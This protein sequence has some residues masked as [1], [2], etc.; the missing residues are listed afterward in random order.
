[1]TDNIYYYKND[2][3]IP[4]EDVDE[5]F[6]L[7]ESNKIDIY[8]YVYLGPK[9]G[10]QH[11]RDVIYKYLESISDNENCNSKKYI[12]FMFAKL[13]DGSIIG[14]M[15]RDDVKNFILSNNITRDNLFYSHF[16]DDPD[17]DDIWKPLSEQLWDEL[18]PLFHEKA[19]Y[20]ANTNET[21]I[22][23]DAPDI[24]LT[25]D[26]ILPSD[27]QRVSRSHWV[28]LDTIKPEND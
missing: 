8:T 5:F 17:H 15:C 4:I 20:E 11:Y 28:R 26:D 22:E 13:H 14:P 19:Q 24:E 18:K 9:F 3:V 1:M 25:D 27:A 16:K 10:W 23:T 12:K 6:S 21:K 2:N 7:R